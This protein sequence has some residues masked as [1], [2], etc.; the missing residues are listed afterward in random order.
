MHFLKINMIIIIEIGGEMTKR[1]KKVLYYCL[2]VFAGLLMSVL[3]IGVFQLA[4]LVYQ[5]SIEPSWFATFLVAGIFLLGILF[6]IWAGAEAWNK[7]Y[8]QGVRGEK[9]T[10]EHRERFDNFEKKF[11][12]YAKGLTIDTVMKWTITFF[13]I[14]LMIIMTVGVACVIATALNLHVNGALYIFYSSF[15][16]K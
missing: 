6:G 8:E 10:K 14:Y 16:I 2:W 12:Q 11:F 5:S 1:D 9:Y 7:I 3:L 4:S 15:I 13:L